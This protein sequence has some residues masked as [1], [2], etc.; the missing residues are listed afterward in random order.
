MVAAALLALLAAIVLLGVSL[1]RPDG[2]AFVWLSVAADALAVTLLV[3][4]LGRRR[5]KGQPP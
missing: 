2:L 3:W 4:A 1:V 5:A